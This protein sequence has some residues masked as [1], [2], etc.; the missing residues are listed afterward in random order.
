[1]KLLKFIFGLALF[2]NLLLA[3]EQEP[4]F[5]YELK[6]ISGK[7][8]KFTTKP[9]GL[10]FEDIKDKVVLLNF[11][12]KNC[13]PCLKEI[14]H[15]VHLQDKYKDK[16]QIIAVHAQQTMSE[17]EAQMFVKLKGINY[18]IIDTKESYGLMDFIM[19]KTGWQGMIPFMVL[20]DQKGEALTT[21]LGMQDEKA[22]E[23]DLQRALGMTQ[24]TGK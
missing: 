19:A 8:H 21:Y 3:Q 22:L 10:I 12:G 9:T 16:Y 15:L 5:K 6:D 24:S 23:N 4:I 11:F 17:Q 13:P 7:T 1:M 18:P 20:F 14:P 2:G